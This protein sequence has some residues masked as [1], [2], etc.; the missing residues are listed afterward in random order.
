MASIARPLLLILG[1]VA[2]QEPTVQGD[3]AAPQDSAP[4][5]DSGDSPPPDTAPDSEA[6]CDCDDGLYCNG[7]E[8]CDADGACLP[9]SPP[10]AVDDGDPCTLPTACDEAVDAWA[11]E[12]DDASPRCVPLDPGPTMAITDHVSVWWPSNHRPNET[13]PTVEPVLYLASGTYGLTF[14]ESTGSLGHLGW[15]DD[16]MGPVEALDRD[17]A[18]LEALPEVSLSFEAGEAA[19]PVPATGFMGVSGDSVNRLRM[20]EGGLLMNRLE[21][22]VVTYAADATLAGTVQMAAM[23]RHVVFTHTVSGTGAAAQTARVRLNGPS[24]SDLPSAEWLVADTALTLRDEDGAGWLFVVYPV[25]GRQPTLAYSA[26]AGLVAEVSTS[27]ATSQSLSL[28]VAPLTALNE[29]EIALYVDP[30]TTASVWYT[31]LDVDGADV[32][33]ATLAP[34]DPTLGAFRPTLGSLQDAGAGRRPDWEVEATHTHYG[35]HRL[36]IETVAAEPISVPL[37]LWGSDKLSWYITGGV[38]LLRDEAGEPL[39]IPVQHSKNWHSTYWYHLYTQPTVP[40]GASSPMELVMIS[41]R[42][43]E[44]YA[45]SHAQLSLIGWGSAGGRWEES[46]LGAFGESVTYDPDVTLGRSM[47][48]DVRPFLVQSLTKW[49]WTGNVGGADFLRYTT[50]L[51]PTLQ[52]RLGRVRTLAAAPGP[53]Q[54]DVTY[55]GVSS[56]G[57]IAA[58]IRTQLA[59][60]DDMVRVYYTLDYTFLTDVRYSRLAFFQM[61]AD[62]YGDNGFSRYAFGDAAGLLVEGAVPDHRTTG[63]AS[64]LDRGIALA[65]DQPWVMLFENLRTT[66]SLPEHYADVGFIVRAFSAD[67]GGTALTTPHI[68]LNRTYNGNSQVAFEV[69]LPDAEGAAWCGAPCGGERR[70][71]PAGS[72]VHL[73]IEYVVPPSDSSRYYGSSAWLSALSAGVVGSPDLMIELASGNKLTVNATTGTLRRAQPIEVEVA[74]GALAAELEVTG[75]RGYLPMRFVGLNRHDGWRLEQE[76]SGAWE[77]VDLSVEGMDDGQM[78]LDL[79]TGTYAFTQ[80]VPAAAAA[81]R[82]R[83]IWLP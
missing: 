17:N 36:A 29:D 3:K 22:P 48:D 72:T 18:D 54:T 4:L 20:S 25:D 38:A 30:S 57:A 45:A 26:E 5:P 31:L 42:W 67:I 60:T 35:R 80:V 39:G 28:L 76:V 34:W 10:E 74:P 23:P 73:V 47:L 65:G 61:A 64:D 78:D 40:P 6:P 52:R 44:V 58:T 11:T 63:Y 43:G 69:G 7:A 68:N 71:V 59:G 12:N 41:S 21:I 2:C 56:D 66:D 51:A 19:A 37:A 77:P 15:F 24:L 16:A 55:A 82:Y 53:R 83:L 33:G 62:T 79:S 49:S 14:D 75:G 1:L 70:F 9:G 27:G 32:G 46:A 8:T 13:W 50:D 81:T